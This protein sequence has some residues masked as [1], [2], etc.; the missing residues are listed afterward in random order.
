MG[1]CCSKD[2]N[3]DQDGF[4]RVIPRTSKLGL[5]NLDDQKNRFLTD[6]LK[7]KKT[8][9]MEPVNVGERVHSEN[10]EEKIKKTDDTS[11]NYLNRVNGKNH[12]KFVQRGSQEMMRFGGTEKDMDSSFTNVNPLGNNQLLP[13]PERLDESD[14]H[15]VFT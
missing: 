3:G 5:K 7:T 9:S 8:G 13:L 14:I 1:D 12:S 11:R 15:D 4:T 10:V 6:N 2:K